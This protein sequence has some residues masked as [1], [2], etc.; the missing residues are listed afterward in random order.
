LVERIESTANETW[1]VR[2]SA[3]D[4]RSANVL[5]ALGRRGSPR[6]LEVPGEDLQKV[7]YRVIE[8]E[9][10]R[11]QEVMVVGGGNAAVESVFALLDQGECASVSISYRKATFARC[12]KQN[13]QRIDDEIRSGRVRAHLSTQVDSITEKELVL[14]DSAGQRLVIPNDS[15]V[16]Q[17]GGTAPTALLQDIG[18]EIVT[19]YG[20]A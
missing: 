17:V 9:V 15:V 19:K 2:S 6:K 8:P 3:G 13:R 18:I 12:R 1:T 11:G 20:E 5:L 7:S 4:F 10:F 14:R 16:V